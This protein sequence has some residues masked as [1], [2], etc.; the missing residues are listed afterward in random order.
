EQIMVG[1]AARR[2]SHGAQLRTAQE[3]MERPRLRVGQFTAYARNG[4]GLWLRSPELSWFDTDAGRYLTQATRA[5]DG[6]DW[7]TV[8]PAD[9]Q[10]IVRQLGEML[11]ALLPN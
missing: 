8:A 6:H 1:P 4:R 5:R 7:V 11:T 9:N 10:R 3:I 2:S